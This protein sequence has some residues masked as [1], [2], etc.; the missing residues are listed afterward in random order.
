MGMVGEAS[1]HC[2]FEL[3]IRNFAKSACTLATAP[4]FRGT[5]RVVTVMMGGWVIGIRAQ[6]A[7]GHPARQ[8]LIMRGERGDSRW[9]P[10]RS[11]AMP[12]ARIDARPFVGVAVAAIFARMRGP[13]P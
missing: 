6:Q 8:A 1:L 10:H 11:S 9:T 2:E 12:V 4:A 5:R 3:H 7:A 13:T